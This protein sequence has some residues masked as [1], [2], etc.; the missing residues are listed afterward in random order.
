MNRRDFLKGL[1][2]ALAALGL[3]GLLVGQQVRGDN[4]EQ[5]KFVICSHE[6]FRRH[7]SLRGF[8]AM[9]GFHPVHGFLPTGEGD[10]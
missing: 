7:L 8:W 5:W 6:E 4:T 9:P 2:G 10:T 1:A 3:P